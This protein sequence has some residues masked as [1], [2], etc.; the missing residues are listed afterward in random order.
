MKIQIYGMQTTTASF[1]WDVPYGITGVRTSFSED[2]EGEPDEESSPPI[3]EI[4]YADK[5]DGVWYFHLAFQNRNGWGEAAHFKIQAD[6][7]PPEA[8]ELSATGGDLQAELNF[9]TTDALS[10][11]NEYT[12]EVNGIEVKTVN[13]NELSDEGLYTLTGL[14]PG[15]QKIKVIAYDNAGK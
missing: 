9:L 3:A 8:F 6:S 1:S 4:T 12:I 2:P 10:G 7:I 13:P 15:D 14:S 11:V 5:E